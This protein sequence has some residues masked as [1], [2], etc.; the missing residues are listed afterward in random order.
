[1]ANQSLNLTQFKANLVGGGARPNLFRV[2]LSFPSGIGIQNESALVTAGQFMIKSANLPASQ[3]GVIE[4][5][6]RG[7]VLKVAGDRTFEPW[8][9]T[10][11]NDTN[12]LIRKAMEKWVRQINKEQE[13]TGLQNPESYQ[14]D[15]L[16]TQL[17]REGNEIKAY[18]FY[19]TFPTNV[20]AI[21]LAFD[22][23][24]TIEEFTVEFQVQWWERAALGGTSNTVARAQGDN[25][26]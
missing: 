4:V 25:E 15:M 23:N 7:R 11:I 5:P 17:D 9:I 26:D 3:L 21:D 1:M 8:T 19:S 2:D 22:S 12:F 18:R 14:A 13:N 10:V 6:F 24:D 16:V 20:S